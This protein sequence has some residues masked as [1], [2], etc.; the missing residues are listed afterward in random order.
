MYINS[1]WVDSPQRIPVRSPYS[2][3][4]IDEVPEATPVHVEEALSAAEKAAKVMAGLTAYERQQIL[5]R[6]ADLIAMHSDDPSRTISLEVGKPISEARIE[7][8][9]MPDLLRLCAFEGS[10]VRGE[11]LPLDAQAGVR[12]KLGLT[13]RVP[14]G[15]VLAITPFNYPLL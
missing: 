6:A 11:T 15:V 8:G 9:R 10:Q 4:L 1:Q 7:V 5:R 3:Q 2:T 12:D 14:C 13:W